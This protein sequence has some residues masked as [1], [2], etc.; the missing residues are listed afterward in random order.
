[1]KDL[2]S[3]CENTAIRSVLENKIVPTISI[4]SDKKQF[5]CDTTSILLTAVATNV[6]YHW[7]NLTTAST[8]TAT[9]AGEYAVMVKDL[10]NGCENRANITLGENLVKPT[11]VKPADYTF[12][13]GTIGDITHTEETGYE[14]LYFLSDRHTSV[15]PT[16]ITKDGTYNITKRD[17]ANGCFSDTIAFQVEFK[18]LLPLADFSDVEVCYPQT[19][20]I[21]QP[22]ETGYT[23]TYYMSDGASILSNPESISKAGTYYIMKTETATGCVSERK[24][25]VV[26]I[27]EQPVMGELSPIEVCY[28]N[29]VDIE[30][31]A[32]VGF[33]FTYYD[34][35]GI[36]I[37]SNVSKIS[38]SGTYYITKTNN[39]TGCVSEKEPIKVTINQLPTFTIQNPDYACTPNTV[40]I[41]QAE[42]GYTFRYYDKNKTEIFNAGELSVSGTYYITKQDNITT[43]VSN[44]VPVEVTVVESPVAFA[45]ED[46]IVC[47]NSTTSLGQKGVATQT[48]H[49]TPSANLTNVDIAN[50]TATVVEDVEYTLTVTLKNYPRCTDKDMVKLTKSK[51]PVSLPITGGGA[52]C[53]GTPPYDTYVQVENTQLLTEYA[54]FHNG[55]QYDQ[56][57]I[58]VDPGL[59]K[60]TELEEGSYTVQA[61]N[62]DG[63]IQKMQ[64]SVFVQM[65]SHPTASITSSSVNICSGDSVTITIKFFGLAPYAATYKD[66]YGVTYNITSESSIYTFQILPTSGDEF[67]IIKVS[68]SRCQHIYEV[69]ERPTVKIDVAEEISAKIITSDVDNTI[70]FGDALT[71]EAKVKKETLHYKWSTDETDTIITVYPVRDTTVY[72][73]QVSDDRGCTLR[74][75]I[76]IYVN[77]LPEVDFTGLEILEKEEVC[78][79]DEPLNMTGTPPGGTFSGP[80]VIGSV[81]YPN[82]SYA[83]GYDSVMY[84]YTDNKGCTNKKVRYYYVNPSPNVN[85]YCPVELGPPTKYKSEY[86]FCRLINDSLNVQGIPSGGYWTLY[87]Q[88]ESPATVIKLEG[89]NAYIKDCLPGTYHL[90]YT[91]VDDKGCENSMM[92]RIIIGSEPPSTLLDMGK[93]MI[94]EGDTLCS[95]SER[96]QIVSTRQDGHFETNDPKLIIEQDSLTG[97]CWINPSLVNSG[98]YRVMFFKMDYTN[99]QHYSWK[100]FYIF[101][102]RNVEALKI[103]NVYCVTDERVS[104]NFT[105]AFDIVGQAYIIK[106]NKDT[107]VNHF[108]WPN[109]D[110]LYF[111]PAWGVGRYEILLEFNDGYCPNTYRFNIKVLPLPILDVNLPVRDYCMGDTIV[112]NCLPEGGFYSTESLGLDNNLLVTDSAGLGTHHITYTFTDTEGGC[113]DS[114][115]FDVF[116]HGQAKGSMRILN[117]NEKYCENVGSTEISGFPI[118]LGTPYF[119]DTTYV[120][121]LGNGKAQIL[122]DKTNYNSSNPVEFNIR[123]DY[124]DFYGQIGSCV[125]SYE[126]YFKVLSKTV[127][128]FGYADGEEICGTIDSLLIIGSSKVNS[129]FE[130]D[131]AEAQSAL[132]NIED[133]KAYIY[134]SQMKEGWY[135]VTYFV[136]YYEEESDEVFCTV[137]K[138]K[139]F[140]VKPLREF[141]PYVVCVDNNNSFAIDN[142]EAGVQYD[143]WVN[144]VLFQSLIGD[145]GTIIFNPITEM[146]YCHFYA[147]RGECRRTN[148]EE[149]YVKPL[150]VSSLTKSV[151][152]FGKSDGEIEVTATGGFNP[153]SF[154]WTDGGSFSAAETNIKNL[155]AATYMVLATD[156]IGCTAADT[157]QITEPTLLNVDV[158]EQKELSCFDS[159]DASVTVAANGG[160]APYTYQWTN[161]GKT[162]IV[163]VG[164]TLANVEAGI[165]EAHATDYNGCEATKIV[166][167]SDKSPMQLTLL[168]LQNVLAYGDSTGSIEI[169]MNGGIE[170]LS[171]EWSGQGV[172]TEHATDQN[173][174]NLPAGNYFLKVTDANGC[175]LDTMFVITQP[176]KL[177]VKYEVKDVTC[178]GYSNGSVSL[179][180]SGGTIPYSYTWYDENDIVIS[181]ERDAVRLSAGIY[182][183]EVVDAVG[184][185]YRNSFKVEE[186]DELTLITSGRTETELLCFGD[187][188]AVL[189]VEP[190]GGVLPY[191]Y[192]WTGIAVKDEFKHD[193]SLYD[194]PA[195]SYSVLVTDKNNCT[196]Q[197]NYI[198]TQP[199]KLSIRIDIVNQPSCYSKADG[200]IELTVS[201]GTAPVQYL[202]RGDGIETAHSTDLN[203]YNLMTGVYDFTATD[204]HNCSANMNFSL[205]DNYLEISLIGETDICE[206]ESV[207]LDFSMNTKTD[208]TIEFT[209]GTNNYSVNTDQAMYTYIATPTENTTYQITRAYDTNDCNARIINDQLSVKVHDVPTITLPET[210]FAVC[211]G[212]SV[213]LEY[214]LTGE[215]PWTIMMSKGEWMYRKSDILERYGYITINPDETSTYVVNKVS[216]PYCTS[217]VSNVVEVDVQPRATLAAKAI[218]QI[219]CKGEKTQIELTL[220]GKAPWHVYYSQNGVEKIVTVQQSP[221]LLPVDIDETTRYL[222]KK[223]ESDGGCST[224]VVGDVQI[225]VLNLPEAAQVITG[226]AEVCTGTK[227]RYFVPTIANATKY[228]WSV[229]E[230]TRIV[231]G[232]ESN[233]ILLEF[234]ENAKAGFITV[235]AENDCGVGESTS[236]FVSPKYAVEVPTQ[237]IAPDEICVSGELQYIGTVSIPNAEKYEWSLPYGFVIED[238]DESADIWV[239]L[240]HDAV[241]GTITVMGKN[242]CNIGPALSKEIKIRQMPKVE[243]GANIY[244]NCKSNTQLNAT[245]VTPYVGTWRVAAGK[246]KATFANPNNP[247]TEVSDLG[248][249]ENYLIWEV[250]NGLCTKSDTVMVY[251]NSADKAEVEITDQHITCENEILLRATEPMIGT[252][253]WECVVG[254]AEIEDA[255]NNITMATNLDFGKNVF[256]WTTKNGFCEDYTFV[257]IQSSS[258]RKFAFAGRNDTIFVTDYRLNASMPVEGI[259]GKWSVVYGDAKIADKSSYG[260]DV[261]NLSVGRNIF[262]WTVSSNQCTAYSEVTILYV[263]EPVALFVTDADSGC[264]PFDI[265]ITNSTVGKA[266]FEW[267]FGDGTTSTLFNPRHI[268]QNAGNYEITLTAKGD[269]KTD[270]YKKKITVIA[271]PKIDITIMQD[272]LYL[273][274]ASLLLINNSDEGAKYFWDFGNGDTSTER[275]PTYTYPAEGVF[276]I[277]Y[278]MEDANSCSDSIKIPNAVLVK[279]EGFITFPNAFIPNKSEANGGKFS[280]DDRNND[281]FYPVSQGVVEYSLQIF[282]RWGEEIFSTNDINVG[283]D[284]YLDGKLCQ[285]GVYVYKSTGKFIDGRDFTRKGEVL[286]I[287]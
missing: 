264:Q 39:A 25:I 277:F 171:F 249:G 227:E 253:T 178:F 206:G 279:M 62:I 283:W 165:Y 135:S 192:E 138:S 52:Y 168:S 64:N 119:T 194:L 231:N 117:L 244:T 103:P 104:V 82:A 147:S 219:L 6:S 63:C 121:D 15:V 23:F 136:D 224:P 109:T 66:Q 54:L 286:L 4:I 133:G 74:D 72:Y 208:W 173:L 127:D 215:V 146:A 160:T 60:W 3:G 128:F 240:N 284:G 113:V 114:I 44:F 250:N 238:G 71:L 20:S 247:Q 115:K 22:A 156:S 269:L 21:V 184:V 134:P 162:E 7:N 51:Y 197:N 42:L 205:E 212:E 220:T 57:R 229:P 163:A 47:E 281:V 24:P 218:N 176:E 258:P 91:Y 132:E 207:D 125:N 35:D 122:F 96:V 38:V 30:Q 90:R 116:V 16:N 65:Y 78:S 233:Q 98:K 89:G 267:D 260:T 102:P 61:R 225:A 270:V 69:G 130:I 199:D 101:S 73:L 45:G 151:S 8:L 222:F 145:G 204:S 243:A 111:D 12:C 180:I 241:S 97:Q 148:P 120:K 193:A 124:I 172:P 41:E 31:P 263:K 237:I 287:Q 10:S 159:R 185:I 278:R 131:V 67:S 9:T 166:T 84:T 245:P 129:H 200:S 14:F 213:E 217:E 43:C 143:M 110:S 268:Y 210:K 94:P 112:F 170:P 87:K 251:N 150:K 95:R 149:F 266:D 252:G 92:K 198:V 70:C 154:V 88:D 239:S 275:V 18:P 153:I 257:T 123:E 137:Q 106:D 271:P 19:A 285:S 214:R 246:G 242:R 187:S 202:W 259:T 144:G 230:G 80:N 255:N 86:I 179:E 276:D 76:I 83:R 5:T 209:D 274:Q 107:I 17:I 282:N 183:V 186:P 13:K 261:S 58:P 175:R 189:S 234:S 232:F 262:R 85:W 164:G 181:T 81:Y 75:S 50:P 28:P 139:R 280:L 32:E 221:Y 248:L 68:D 27:N 2:T 256:R 29:T 188:T 108:N 99:C 40:D 265:N 161:A 254:N 37:L 118:G 79:N 100:D 196:I 174:Q 56:W 33:S 11:L 228:R 93:I 105:A 26:I 216:T 182:S 177:E 273:P 34:T 203:Q 201:G 236:L 157:I 141:N 36:S 49:W 235:Y 1:M 55:T 126:Q 211:E 158:T 59:V 53:E 167:I 46:R 77:P 142:S 190:R 272:T 48:Y 169:A 155:D 223:V 195:G 152:C 140:Y 191:A 226:N